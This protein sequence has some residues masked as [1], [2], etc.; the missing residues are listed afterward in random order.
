MDGPKL[1]CFFTLFHME[2]I[3]LYNNQFVL[4]PLITVVY[5][6]MTCHQP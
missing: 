2:M 1:F 3:I 6:I 5:N 4:H